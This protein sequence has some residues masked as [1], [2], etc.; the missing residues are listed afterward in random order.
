MGNDYNDFQ[1]IDNGICLGAFNEHSSG[2]RLL[3]PSSS[4][5]VPH[6]IR[7]ASNLINWNSKNI[8]LVFEI[9]W[10]ILPCITVYKRVVLDN[11]NPT[12]TS[13]L[14][15]F[16]LEI[17]L[18]SFW[19]RSLHILILCHCARYIPLGNH[20]HYQWLIV[21]HSPTEHIFV[22]FEKFPTLKYDMFA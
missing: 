17:I 1:Y 10:W 14:R 7:I 3:P 11:T 15:F 16:K 19:S 21:Y 18:R 8:I 22:Y 5:W 12:M 20:K 2:L 13:W 6:L 9:V 4:P